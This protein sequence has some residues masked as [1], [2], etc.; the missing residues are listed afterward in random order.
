MKRPSRPLRN[1]RDVLNIQDYLKAHK[2]ERDYVLFTLGVMTG[3]RA[4]DLVKLQVR[5][6]K[7]ALRRGEFTIKEGKKYNH[8]NIRKENRRPRTVEIPTKLNKLLKDYIKNMKDYEYLFKSRKGRNQAIGVPAISNTLK[9]AAEYFG[10]YDIT[11]HSM[12]KTYAYKIYIESKKDAL[13]VKELLG[14]SSIEETKR[15]LGVERDNINQYNRSLN[16]FIR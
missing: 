13:V 2:T 10:L 16:D 12:R 3:Y 11:A 9:E 8:K 15:Y 14:H 4:G 6:V 5:D 7:E 1:V